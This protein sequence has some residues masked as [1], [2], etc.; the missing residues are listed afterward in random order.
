[1]G[2]G[3]GDIYLVLSVFLVVGS[4]VL[5]GYEEES[6]DENKVVKFVVEVVE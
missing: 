3:D 2:E 5:V 6:L 1:M 4:F